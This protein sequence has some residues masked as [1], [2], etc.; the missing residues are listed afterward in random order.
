MTS[1]LFVA[2][3]TFSADFE[4]GRL[5]KVERAGA[6]HYRLHVPGEVDRDGRNR[7]A[8]WYAFRVDGARGRRLTLDMVDLPGE[9]NYQ[10]NRGAIVAGTRPFYSYD[11]RRWTVLDSTEYDAS[12]PR[13][14]LRIRPE[15]DRV[16]IAHQ[17]PYTTRDLEALLSDLRR[18]PGRVDIVSA[19]KT[20]GGRDI[21]LLTIGEP[22]IGRPVIWLLFRQ[23]AWESGSSWAAEGAIR[24]LLA[25]PQPALFKIFPMCDPDG[26]ARGGVRFNANGY[27][28]NRNWDAVDPKTM[29]EIAAQRNAILGW[30]DSGG[31]VDLLVTLH[32]DEDPE[33]VAG[34]PGPEHEPLL[35]RFEAALSAFDTF[36]P[37]RPA[38][39]SPASTTEGKPGRMAVYQGLYRD[40]K[41]PAF[42]IEQRITR[43]PKLGRQPDAEDRKRFGEHLVRAA[44][45]AVLGA[46]RSD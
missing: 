33:Y 40:R 31:R 34:P 1:L 17:P 43:H 10:P 21:P 11:G 27:D 6:D 2:A 36:A 32:N 30:V 19:G 37:T 20:V 46:K 18:R 39:L 15:R 8:S 41:L 22:S 23:H 26:V 7:Q 25:T 13:L 3:I 45:T 38:A 16:Y 28:L 5:G 24:F 42:L 4:G 9:Y 14:R 12:E 35:R 44:L 29:P